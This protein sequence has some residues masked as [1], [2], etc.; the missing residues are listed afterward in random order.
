MPL[1]AD[2]GRVA[3]L[4]GPCRPPQPWPQIKA[5]AADSCLLGRGGQRRG[6]PSCWEIGSPQTLA[7]AIPRI[8]AGLGGR[9]VLCRFAGTEPG[10]LECSGKTPPSS[11][12]LWG[13]PLP[14]PRG[15]HGLEPVLP[16]RLSRWEGRGLA[17]PTA[18]RCCSCALCRHGCP[19]VQFMTVARRMGRTC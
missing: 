4:L 17:G 8:P 19:W 18:S 3:L 6:P 7:T 9:L 10:Q 2:G 12:E 5:T 11:T 1:A 13:L 16:Q 14:R 15:A